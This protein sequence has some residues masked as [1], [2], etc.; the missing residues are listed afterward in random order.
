MSSYVQ[1][2][3]SLQL[4]ARQR[5]K[6]SRSKPFA[7]DYWFFGAV[8][9]LLCLGVVM[10]GSAS[11]SIAEK[12]MQQPMYYLLRQLI[13]VGVGLAA[14]YC[15]LQ[16][17]LVFWEKS[18]PYLLIGAIALLVVV[19]VPGIGLQVNGSTRWINFGVANLQPSEFVKL[20]FVVYLAGYLV[21]R[22][23][24]IRETLKGFIKPVALLTITSLLLFAE[25]DFGAVVVLSATVFGMLFLA[26]VRLLHFSLFVFIV[27]SALVA[28]ALSAPYRMERLTTFLNPWDDPFNSGFQLTQ[29]LIAFG[30]GEWLGVGLGGSVQKLFY[31]PEAH[32]DFVFA[33]IAEELGL[34]GSFVVIGLFSIVIWR[35]FSIASIAEQAGK[36]FAAY[37]AYGVGLWFSLQVIINLGVNMGVLP[38]KG[39]TL[40]LM[41]YGG[42]SMVSI[43]IALAIV[44]RVYHETS[45]KAQ[46]TRRKVKGKVNRL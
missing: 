19:L 18:G 25:P 26:G 9:C 38:T 24:E 15:V 46:G 44:M 28:M 30:R 12:E 2:A 1:I 29:A 32:T 43:C 8:I 45:N 20:F 34:L 4:R 11:I 21:R 7:I 13:Y 39:L 14:A 5:S 17:P 27:F 33:V 36:R 10:T 40:P 3:N 37:L 41:S 42:S 35:T 16:I 6:Q 23:K 22:K 31:L